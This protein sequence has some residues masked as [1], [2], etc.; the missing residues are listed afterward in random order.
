MTGKVV[1]VTGCSK[2]GIGF[3]LCE[4]FAAKGC[5]V[6]A[7]A[8]RLEAMEG[9]KD[10]NI[11]TLKL[12]VTSDEDVAE[13]VKTV[14]ER[15]GSI[16]IVVNNAGG[17]CSGPLMETSLDQAQKTFDTN[18]IS[19]LRL[20]QA[21]F[22]HMA[23]KRSGTIV[24]VG[25]VVGDTPSPW[26]G[27]YCATKAALLRLSEIL[28]MEVAPFNIHVVHISPGGVKTNITVHALS[29]LSLREDSFYK[30]YFDSMVAVLNRVQGPGSLTA[31]QFAQ[32]VVREVV[33]P[34]PPRYMTLGAGAWLNT[35]LQWFPRSFVCW[36]MWRFVAGKPKTA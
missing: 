12:D 34:N 36:L 19:V 16:D 33:K 3:A 9:F 32:Q 23:T 21:V 26:G 5:K 17:P 2:G 8:R 11:S 13:V 18:V 7:T 35:V 14:L 31:A 20:S 6:Y 24:N 28:Y 4:E 29:Q 27:V 1:I 25:S 10:P 15:E 22:P 30:P